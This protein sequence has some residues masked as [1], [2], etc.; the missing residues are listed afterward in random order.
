MKL[1]NKLREKRNEAV[2][3]Q[4]SNDTTT[5]FVEFGLGSVFVPDILRIQADLESCENLVTVSN[6]GLNG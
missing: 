4:S 2:S 6:F 1:L 3:P 5:Y